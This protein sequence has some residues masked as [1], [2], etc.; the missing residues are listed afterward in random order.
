MADCFI[1][2]QP[3]LTRDNEVYGYELLY[4]NSLQNEMGNINPTVAT[5]RVVMNAF[6][7]IGLERVAGSHRAFIHVPDNFLTSPDLVCFPP[8][9]VVLQLADSMI[10]TDEIRSAVARLKAEG[11]SI[12]LSAYRRN[13]PVAELLPYADIVK[14]DA[15]GVEDDV[16]SEELA[17]LEGRNLV[18]IA[19]RVET[20]E[21]RD[22][23]EELGFDCFQGYFLSKPEII[24]GTRLPTNRLAVLQLVTKISDPNISLSEL[25]DLIAMDAA[26]SMRVLRF[27]NSPL[28]GLSNEIESIHHAVVLLGRE[29]IR[30]WVMLLAIASLDNSIPELIKT[31]FVRAKLCERLATEA[32]LPGKESYFTAGL[33]SLM[34]AI[35]ARPMDELLETLPF[36]VELKSALTEG[37]GERGEAILCAKQLER[38][39]PDGTS[40]CD[41]PGERIAD[42]YLDSLR[43]AD[44]SVV[45]AA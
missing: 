17:S 34:D 8:Q 25:E 30:N 23:M 41:V 21:R 45:A 32:G 31:A 12:A 10:A 3:I 28:S 4:R 39:A 7:D 26:L 11:Y 44:E 22:R 37:T 38:G 35:M 36:T 2:R 19:K 43:W 14:L 40:F 33:F 9:R 42:L 5:S 24:T 27:V 1:G 29:I 15:L 20:M 16:L 13:L 6:V 18:K